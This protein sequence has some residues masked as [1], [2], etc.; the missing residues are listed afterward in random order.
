MSQP[1]SLPLPPRSRTK[2]SRACASGR[3]HSQ[4][5]SFES[6]RTGIAQ[7]RRADTLEDLL[8]RTRRA[9]HDPA[10]ARA[11]WILADP[12]TQ[13]TAGD[14]QHR[15][16]LLAELAGVLDAGTLGIDYQPIRTPVGWL[17]AVCPA[18]AG[19]ARPA[20]PGDLADIAELAEHT[21]L[22]A[23]MSPHMLTA[24]A[25]D[26]AT[27]SAADRPAPAVLLGLPGA[28]V[29]DEALLDTVTAQAADSGL[30]G[31]AAA[32]GDPGLGPDRRTGGPAPTSRFPHRTRGDSPGADRRA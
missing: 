26:A 28:T 22:L 3:V 30:G 1:K 19:S 24:A 6:P 21:G 2:F 8:R 13:P 17:A 20:P 32:T 14:D 31:R 15:V 29:H 4:T 10:H 5:P 27:W 9:L 16:E 18:R 25:R 11:A 23:A 12:A 7:A